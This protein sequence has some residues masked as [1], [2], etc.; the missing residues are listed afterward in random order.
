MQ[1]IGKSLIQSM[2]GVPRCFR[3]NRYEA[4]K[5]ARDILEG[6]QKVAGGRAK[7]YPG[8]GMVRSR[9]PAGCQNRCSVR[10]I[11]H[12]AGM[13]EWLRTHRGVPSRTSLLHPPATFWHPAGMARR[14]V[15]PFSYSTDNSG[16]PFQLGETVHANA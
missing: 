7:R 9:T 11:W 14:G 12:P 15:R 8:S 3:W 16:V 5:S 2:E 1:A 10:K 4:E 13:Q 6:C